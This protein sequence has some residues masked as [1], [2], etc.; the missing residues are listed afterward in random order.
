MN[1]LGKALEHYDA[2]GLD[3]AEA[4]ARFQTWIVKLIQGKKPV[5]VGFNAPFDWSFINYYFHRFTGEPV[6][7]RRSGY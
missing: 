7:L 5:F 2:N 1:V 6:W 4:M 3:A